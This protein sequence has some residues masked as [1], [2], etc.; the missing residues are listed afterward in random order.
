M[1]DN[2]LENESLIRQSSIIPLDLKEANSHII[3][4]ARQ[5]VNQ[6][7]DYRG[8]SRPPFLPK[9]YS[10]FVNIKEIQKANLEDTSGL[11]LK[12][13]DGYVIKVN[14]DHYQV[15]QNFSCAHEIGHILFN[16]LK[17]E[18]YV[19]TIEYR[20]SNIQKTMEI[21]SRA[22]E[23][24][25][26]A[27]AAE[28]LMP[29][30]VFIKCLS[31]FGLSITSIEYLAQT[32]Q[33]SVQAVTNRIS[34]VNIEPCVAILWY[35]WPKSKPKGLQPAKGKQ[36]SG[37]ANYLQLYEPV[38]ASSALYKAYQNDTLVKTWKLFRDGNTVK[39]IPVQAK[40]F[41]RGETRFV[42]S[43]AFPDRKNWKPA[44]PLGSP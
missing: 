38:R 12:F 1:S 32:F 27:A 10:R 25:C 9:E 13:H 15:R 14:Q 36:L 28:L 6:L 20:T 41:G 18:D 17:L 11:L 4:K 42:I 8:H 23:G 7:V 33:V 31:T 5:L 2:G 40:G 22:R 24:L 29:K 19:R 39:R 21:R 30:S 44:K 3:E 37:K 43:L 16:D 26:D 34:E 35:P